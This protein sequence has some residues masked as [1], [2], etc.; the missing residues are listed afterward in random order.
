MFVIYQ[1][2]ELQPNSI[3]T[4]AIFF[5][6]KKYIFHFILAKFWLYFDLTAF[7]YFFMSRCTFLIKNVL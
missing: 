4:S 1:I 5:D 2:E 7:A 3:I 6:L